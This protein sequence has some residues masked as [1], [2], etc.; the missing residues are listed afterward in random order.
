MDARDLLRRNGEHPK[1]VVLS[2][3]VLGGERK[4]GDVVERA[5]VVRMHANRVELG[6]VV[7][8]VLVRVTHC[9]SQPNELKRLEF[10]A[11]HPLGGVLFV[12]AGGTESGLGLGR[13]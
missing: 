9:L 2:E 12:E 10:V 7:R 1:W 11:G 13:R 6:P 4:F 8:H 5:D 3:V